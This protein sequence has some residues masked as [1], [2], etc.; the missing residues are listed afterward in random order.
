MNDVTVAALIDCGIRLSTGV[1]FDDVTARVDE[2]E[3][4]FGQA[5]S[6]FGLWLGVLTALGEGRSKDVL[7]IDPEC[8]AD[9]PFVVAELNRL[10]GDEFV[11]VV[12][13]SGISDD[14]SP[15]SVTVELPGAKQATWEFKNEGDW[16][17][18]AVISSTPKFSGPIPAVGCTNLIRAM[19]TG[20]TTGSPTSSLR[21]SCSSAASSRFTMHLVPL[22]H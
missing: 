18:V 11:R 22:W 10:A 3:A 8:D 9:Y 6:D 14:E 12:T 15:I 20:R 13:W 7:S 2:F 16:I 5:P 4:L 17:E 1:T 21:T 19:L